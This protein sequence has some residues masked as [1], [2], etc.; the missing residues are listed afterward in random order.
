MMK[1]MF[2]IGGEGVDTVPPVRTAFDNLFTIYEEFQQLMELSAYVAEDKDGRNVRQMFPKSGKSETVN[3]LREKFKEAK[4]KYV[5]LRDLGVEER[6]DLKADYYYSPKF[7]PPV[8]YEGASKSRTAIKY[9]EKHCWPGS[10]DDKKVQTFTTEIDHICSLVNLRDQ[11]EI[12][13]QK[14]VAIRSEF[15]K[16]VTKLE[17]VIDFL[18]I[19]LAG[20]DDSNAQVIDKTESEFREGFKS[21]LET[22]RALNGACIWSMAMIPHHEYGGQYSWFTTQ[23]LQQHRQPWHQYIH[24]LE[25]DD[26]H[27]RVTR[28]VKLGTDAQQIGLE[29]D[30]AK[31]EATAELLTPEEGQTIENQRVLFPKLYHKDM[32]GLEEGELENSPA[33]SQSDLDLLSGDWIKR[34]SWKK[35][36]KSEEKKEE[37][38]E[39]DVNTSQYY[40]AQQTPKLPESPPLASSAK[41]KPLT[42][43]KVKK[44]ESNGSSDDSLFSSVSTHSLAS[45]CSPEQLKKKAEKR[46]MKLN[47]GLRGD[48][49][50]EEHLK[51]MK[52]DANAMSKKIDLH[53]DANDEDLNFLVEKLENLITRIDRK[54]EE[55]KIYER[56]TRQLPRGKLITWDGC[57]E[58]YLDFRR[59]MQN[60]LL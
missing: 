8:P 37:E 60:M 24:K 13:I 28:L 5:Y 15:E 52:Y 34:V 41:K 48:G 38:G 12:Q 11:F 53:G 35:E 14:Y 6:S 36:K 33:P 44:A 39:E 22:A 56:K 2:N 4:R 47:K 17:G 58:G 46:I 29:L 51:T 23:R 21:A 26:I 1:K 19:L 16:R 20:Q 27:F 42:K 30:I 7:G 45:S 55:K 3:I 43:K 54:L 10:S 18:P 32:E 25:A 59:Q 40:D 57:I 31:M 49:L 50:S 9:A